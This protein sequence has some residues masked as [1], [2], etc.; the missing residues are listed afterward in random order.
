[1]TN[2]KLI[3]ENYIK[4]NSPTTL[5]V[6]MKDLNSHIDSAQDLFLRVII[7]DSFMEYLKTK[8][9][10]QTLSPDETELVQN[11][12]QPAVLWRSLAL[13]SPFLQ[14]NLRAKGYMNNTDDAGN[15][16]D[17]GQ[18]KFLINELKNRAEVH[19]ELLSRYLCTNSAKFS[20]YTQQD[21]LTQPDGSSN[22][23]SGLIFY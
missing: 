15:P 20:Q 21:G 12:I 7:G 3:T 17:F 16:A 22:F 10:L 6:Q 9:N 18:V 14:Y 2:I 5:G 4:V 13:A 11:Y 8:F 19:E 1:M 23:D